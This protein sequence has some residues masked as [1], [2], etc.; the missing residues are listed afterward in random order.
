MQVRQLTLDEVDDVA[1]QAIFVPGLDA[2]HDN[3]PQVAT[4]LDHSFEFDDRRRR[5]NSVLCLHV[6]DELPPV[7]GYAVVSRY[8]TVRRHAQQPAAQ[9]AFEAVHHG[10]NDDQRGNAQRNTNQRYERDE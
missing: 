2:V 6:A 3:G 8:E 7:T 5:S 4:G 9:F 10:K 1:G